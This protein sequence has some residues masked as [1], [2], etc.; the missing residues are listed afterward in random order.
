MYVPKHIIIGIPVTNIMSV[1]LVNLY[2]FH[3]FEKI[4]VC[5]SQCT[6]Q[7]A[8]CNDCSCK[9]EHSYY[10]QCSLMTMRHPSKKQRSDPTPDTAS[11][12]E[13]VS[14]ITITVDWVHIL[15]A[16]LENTEEKKHSR[17]SRTYMPEACWTCWTFI[18][19]ALYTTH[20]WTGTDLLYSSLKYAWYHRECFQ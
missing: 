18:L 15:L 7:V 6:L 10:L 2:L 20:L 19:I 17:E 13:P 12:W 8:C 4:M 14:S 5:P 16:D 9:I 11:T 1:I 3:L